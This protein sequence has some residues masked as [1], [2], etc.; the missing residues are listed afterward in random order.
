MSRSARCRISLYLTSLMILAFLPGLAGL[1]DER[2]STSAAPA[3]PA[4]PSG[5]AAFAGTQVVPAYRQADKIAVLRVEG[6]IDY[7]TRISLERR[8]ERAMREGANAVV[9]DINTPGGEVTAMLDICH[10]LK[11]DAPSNT[12]AWINPNAYSA[13]T[14][15]ALAA[16]EIVVQDNASFG[17]AAPIKA[18]PFGMIQLE[19]SER[20]KLEAPLLEEVIDSARRHHYDEKL[21]QAFVSVGVELWLLENTNTG[22]RVFVDR[23][24]YVQVFGEDPPTGLTAVA[25]VDENAHRMVRPARQERVP[26]DDEAREATAGDAEFQQQLPAPRSRLT[27]A[28]RDSYRVLR[29]VTASDRLLTVRPDDARLYGLATR[30]IR[31]DQELMAYFGAQEL[32]RYDQLWS[33]SLAR[34]LMSFP[35]RAVLLIIFLVALFVELSAPGLGVF[36]ATAAVAL[37]LLVGAP[38]LVG[39]AQWW[40]ILL[41]AIGLLLLTAEIFFIPGTGVAGVLGLISLLVGMVGTFVTGDIGTSQGQYQLWAGITTMITSAFGAGIIIWLLSRQFHTFHVLD[42]VILKSELGNPQTVPPTAPVQEGSLRSGQFRV[43]DV[44]VAYTGLRPAGRADFGGKIVD[45]QSLGGFI[46]QGTPVRIVSV[47]RYVIDV[48]EANE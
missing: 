30:V 3:S 43:G 9:L 29:Q 39:L 25:P 13:G 41:V 28:D 23:A 7:I 19:A 11:T 42:R 36:G 48:E 2:E 18:T 22:E 40:G 1:A 33:E 47:G 21:V 37:L 8:V 24:E 34:F 6:E 12:V 31:N 17:D 32:V 27:A 38:A 35:V 16:R 20:A 26:Q 5:A 10:L 15:I 44:G 46:E 14:F 45:V 4:S